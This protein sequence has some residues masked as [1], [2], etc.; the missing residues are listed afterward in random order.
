MPLGFKRRSACDAASAFFSLA[1]VASIG[2]NAYYLHHNTANG[3][4]PAF[5]GL[6]FSLFTTVFA[7]QLALRP[8]LAPAAPPVRM[9]PWPCACFR[10]GLRASWPCVVYGFLA[11]V[12]LLVGVGYFVAYRPDGGVY[13]LVLSGLLVANAAEANTTDDGSEWHNTAGAAY[14]SLGL[15]SDAAADDA[16]GPTLP[17]VETSRRRCCCPTFSRLCIARAV[18]LGVLGVCGFLLVMLLGGAWLQ[19]SWNG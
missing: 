17:P 6:W 14:K 16:S 7:A 11:F 15:N 18:I 9:F 10:V 4:W 13:G 2:V 19:V 1:G 8:R 3:V 5:L 12:S